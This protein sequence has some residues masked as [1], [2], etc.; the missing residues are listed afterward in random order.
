MP[1][2]TFTITPIPDRDDLLAFIRDSIRTN[3]TRAIDGLRDVTDPEHLNRVDALGLIQ[4]DL[5]HTIEVIKASED[6]S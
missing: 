4:S 3:T 2:P 1:N 6:N 5:E